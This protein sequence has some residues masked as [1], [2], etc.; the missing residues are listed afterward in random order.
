VQEEQEFKLCLLGMI[1]L[2]DK[3]GL[4]LNSL[5]P[6]V[7]A[8]V[9]IGL[10]LGI[11]IYVLAETR[12]GIAI[13]HAGLDTSQMVNGTGGGWTNTTTLSDST[14]TQYKLLT[15]A[16]TN[17]SNTIS[18]SNYTWTAAGVVTWKPD[19]ARTSME[20][21]VTSTFNYDGTDTPEET[22]TTTITG[23]DD[24]ADWIAIIV[25]VLAA[26]IVLGIVLSSF[27]REPGV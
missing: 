17:G 20:V 18:T 25:V 15:V 8:I 11:G 3:Q 7:L 19:L 6:A 26:A 13:D 24:F 5:Y 12:S 21:N 2:K 4:S 27:G 16:V 22:M 14:N 10:V 1:S 9:M 23:V